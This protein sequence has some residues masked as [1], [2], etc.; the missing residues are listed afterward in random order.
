M[1]LA[2]ESLVVTGDSARLQQMLV[3]L[4]LNGAKYTSVGGRVWVELTKESGEAVIRIRDNGVGIRTEMLEKVFDLF[5]QGDDTLHRSASGLGVGLTLVRSIADLHGGRVHAHSA[6]P[7]HGSEFVV[8]LP[9]A[10]SAELPEVEGRRH[11]AGAPALKILI[12]EDN[13]DSRRMLS[14]ILQLD[15]H[16]VQVASDG[17]EGLSAIHASVPRS[18][19]WTS[20]CRR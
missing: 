8:R 3:N 7:G 4:L 15:G 12:V 14:N 1:K 16:E 2:D 11:S 13:D 20:A 6:G 19:L 9:L 5:V 17:E 18:Q 10:A